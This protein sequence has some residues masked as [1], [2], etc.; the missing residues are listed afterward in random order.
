MDRLLTHGISSGDRSVHN[1]ELGSPSTFLIHCS[2]LVHHSAPRARLGGGTA[3]LLPSCRH[4]FSLQLP[5]RR[6][7]CSCSVG[8]WYHRAGWRLGLARAAVSPQVKILPLPTLSQTLCSLL[9]ACLSPKER[10]YFFARRGNYRF[11]A[12]WL[13]PSYRLRYLQNETVSENLC[14]EFRLSLPFAA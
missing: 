5:C 3:A 6:R 12:A 10:L 13:S 1:R 7:K 11:P 4:L 9:P 14:T 2:P 8:A